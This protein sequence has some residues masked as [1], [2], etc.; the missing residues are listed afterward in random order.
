MPGSKDAADPDFVEAFE[1]VLSKGPWKV[2]QSWRMLLGG[3]FNCAGRPRGPTAPVGWDVWAHFWMDKWKL[4][5][6]RWLRT[7]P[8]LT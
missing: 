8:C 4:G 6:S 3:G 2:K 7:R 5:D 1:K